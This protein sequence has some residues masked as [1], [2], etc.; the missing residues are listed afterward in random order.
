[1]SRVAARK[2]VVWDLDGSVWDGTLLEDAVVRPRP[3]AIDAIRLF[4]ERGLLQAVAS[5]NEPAHALDALE[6]FGLRQYFLSTQFHWG[7][8]SESLGR[9]AAE[10]GIS[11]DAMA[12]ID[13]QPFERDEVRARWPEV[14]CVDA[15]DL[16]GLVDRPEFKPQWATAEARQRR[17]FYAAEAERA[18]T[19]REYPGAPDAFLQSLDLRLTIDRAASADLDRIQELTLRTHQLNS[20]GRTFD[21]EALERLIASPEHLVLVA[22]LADKYGD[23][24]R[25]ALAIVA[26]SATDWLIQLLLTSCRVLSRGVGTHLLTCL[27][28]AASA[29]RVSLHAEY[30]ATAVNRSTLVLLRF[31]GFELGATPGVLERRQSGDVDVPAWLQLSTPG[32]DDV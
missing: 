13:D 21:R 30:V 16:R 18:R 8:K 5:R 23:Y 22:S 6:R 26:C 17:C 2:C 25:V 29:R 14:L 19:E 11:H 27:I 7:A 3:E 31:A 32:L 20:T 15:S 1:M 4:D 10:L 12:F 24:G 28:R 9:I